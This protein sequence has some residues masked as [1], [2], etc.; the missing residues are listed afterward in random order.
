MGRFRDRI[1]GGIVG[2]KVRAVT[3]VGG[4]LKGYVYRDG[5]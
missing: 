5:S 1:L 2:A 4:E 3:V